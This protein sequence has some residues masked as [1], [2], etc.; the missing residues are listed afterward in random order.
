M[1][2][3]REFK[4]NQ[5]HK[6]TYIFLYRIQSTKRNIESP[7]PPQKKYSNIIQ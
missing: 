3:Y 5:A 1:F 7:L 4:S 2:L 6:A